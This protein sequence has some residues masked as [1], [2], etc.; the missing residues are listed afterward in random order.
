MCA[1]NHFLPKLLVYQSPRAN[2][3][4]LRKFSFG[5]QDFPSK[6]KKIIRI[7]RVHLF[8]SNSR[9]LKKKTKLANKKTR[10]NDEKATKIIKFTSRRTCKTDQVSSQEKATLRDGESRGIC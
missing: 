6:K 8:N 1:I 4:G 7:P 5:L 9:Y 10:N 3:T 2:R